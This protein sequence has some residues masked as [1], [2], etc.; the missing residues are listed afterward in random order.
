MGKSWKRRRREM[1]PDIAE[2]VAALVAEQKARR[3]A[4]AT[5]TPEM[6]EIVEKV[7]DV[8]R[9]VPKPGKA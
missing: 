6:A 2:Q 3:E 5:L 7:D 9:A 8:K 1:Y 4:G